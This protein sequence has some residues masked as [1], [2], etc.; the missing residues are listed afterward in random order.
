MGNWLVTVGLESTG[1]ICVGGSAYALP[2]WFVA[3]LVLGLMRE[4]EKNG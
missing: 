3:R 4:V 1:E 2:F